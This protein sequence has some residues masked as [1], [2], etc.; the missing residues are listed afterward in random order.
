MNLS[1]YC[2]I[3]GESVRISPIQASR[4]AKQVAGDFNP[5]HDPDAKRF[6][7]PGDL[8]FALVLEKCGISRQ[9]SFTF[10]GMVGPNVSL[11]FPKSPEN[12]FE[13]RDSADR[14]FLKVNRSGPVSK[15]R[16]L[17][18]SFT[19]GYVAFSGHN[20]PHIL[21]P[22]MAEHRVMINTDRPLVV[23]ESMSFGLDRLDLVHPQ[24]ELTETTLDVHGKR[25]NA[26][27][28][29]LVKM[30]GEVVGTGRKK[31]VLSGLREL[32]EAKLQHLV[33]RFDARRTEYLRSH[34]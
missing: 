28:S 12:A 19:K 32:E 25:G 4:F 1:D 15:D 33:E 18:D 14:T 9:M 13:V 34:I 7:V 16:S 6:C 21:V 29:F 3:D 23:Y 20:F 17:I 2:S 22:L 24:L 30:A 8:L 26:H 5:I 10:T 27:L 11:H 31:L